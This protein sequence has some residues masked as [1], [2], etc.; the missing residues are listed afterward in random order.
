V[1]IADMNFLEEN[2]DKINFSNEVE[3]LNIDK[4]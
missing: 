2:Y 1:D 4:K 3:P